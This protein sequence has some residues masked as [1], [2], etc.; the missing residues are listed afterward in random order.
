MA[1]ERLFSIEEAA[2]RLGEISPWTVRSW[3][4][5]GRLRKTKV[6]R[7]TMVAESELERFVLSSNAPTAT[8]D[9]EEQGLGPRGRKQ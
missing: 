6:G 1:L 8:A 9:L 4:S 2:K 3:I 7:R 5:A